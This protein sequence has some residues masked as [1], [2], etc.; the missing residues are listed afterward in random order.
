MTLASKSLASS[1]IPIRPYVCVA[2]MDLLEAMF[3][4]AMGMMGKF[5]RVGWTGREVAL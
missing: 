5:F 2:A 4:G 3:T 1:L